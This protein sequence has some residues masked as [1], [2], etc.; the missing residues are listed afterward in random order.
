MQLLKI[1]YLNIFINYFCFIPEGIQW[2]SS[3]SV[4]SGMAGS[5]K[6][7]FLE[8]SLIPYSHFVCYIVCILEFHMFTCAW[9]VFNS[10][11]GED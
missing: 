11:L 8:I 5:E 2:I 4:W 9:L 1:K 10:F 7:K 6:H 3:L